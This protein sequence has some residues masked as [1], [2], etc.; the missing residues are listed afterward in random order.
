MMIKHF[1]MLMTK[2]GGDQQAQYLVLY[3]I[4]F[5]VVFVRFASWLALK[6]EALFAALS[7]LA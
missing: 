4:L 3:P 5:S 1:D 7:L 6:Y 2:L